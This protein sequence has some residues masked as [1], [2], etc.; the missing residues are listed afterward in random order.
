MSAWKPGTAICGKIARRLTQ[1]DYFTLQ[2]W[3][4]WRPQISITATCPKDKLANSAD[5]V[6]QRIQC[7]PMKIK[8]LATAFSCFSLTVSYAEDVGA[9]PKAGLI[10]PAAE[11]LHKV[12][13]ETPASFED[14]DDPLP[15]SYSLR[16]RMP[17]ARNQGSLNSCVGWCLGYGLLSYL[18]R[19]SASPQRSP[20]Y[21]YYR[22][23]PKHGAP[24]QDTGCS[25]ED[26]FRAIA[27]YGSCDFKSYTDFGKE[28]E[29][30]IPDE[31]KEFRAKIA[32]PPV[33]L[34]TSNITSIKRALVED[35]GKP[36]PAG[37]HL[38]QEFARQGSPAFSLDPKWGV[39]V[40]KR[41][42][43]PNLDGAGNSKNVL[44]AMLI[45]GYD[46]EIGA[47]E[48]LNSYGEEWGDKGYVWIDYRFFN[49]DDAN[50]KPACCEIIYS[51]SSVGPGLSGIIE[52]WGNAIQFLFGAAAEDFE[53]EGY[54]RVATIDAGSTDIRPDDL[55]FEMEPNLQALETLL[56]KRSELTLKDSVSS[57][58]LRADLIVHPSTGDTTLGSKIAELS[59]GE[60]FQVTGLKKVTMEHGKRI[61]YWAK[62]FLVH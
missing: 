23:L 50:G 58:A 54:C 19:D 21:V 24:L 16:Y 29:A 20:L 28:P 13:M 41:A 46:D 9:F 55:N 30:P 40:W 17:P 61:E 8:T 5:T 4:P 44:H 33:E 62:G 3:S 36:L 26:G 38:C 39:K 42:G 60:W 45:T 1:P 7:P 51:Y 57:I 34:A 43:S 12:M 15:P 35:G 31:A 37:F 22:A 56:Q 18:Y 27:R 59:G 11:I 25:F 6:G 52:H 53:P 10:L 32:L 2:Y 14:G 47:F 49:S 48:A